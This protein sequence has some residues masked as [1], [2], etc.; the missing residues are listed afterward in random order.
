MPWILNDDDDE[1][2]DDDDNDDDD[3]NLNRLILGVP[4]NHTKVSAGVVC[5]R[6]S[7][8]VNHHGV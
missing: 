5:V 4:F 6:L 8:P 3:D 1:G 7:H 2:N